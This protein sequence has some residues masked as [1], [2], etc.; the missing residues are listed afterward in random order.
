MVQAYCRGRTGLSVVQGT[1]RRGSGLC[2]HRVDQGSVAAAAALAVGY[3]GGGGTAGS[4]LGSH[5]P[6]A[7][8]R[9][10]SSGRGGEQGTA[11]IWLMAKAL[12]R[13]PRLSCWWRKALE[14]RARVLDADVAH[15][16]GSEKC[17]G[18]E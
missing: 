17:E 14:L 8:L 13:R 1:A 16:R 2:A 11:L 10:R 12:N 4:G 5:G 18:V 6:A 7:G 9:S 15:G 3:Y